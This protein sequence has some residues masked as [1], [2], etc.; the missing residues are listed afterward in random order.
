MNTRKDILFTGVFK[1]KDEETI[2]LVRL[3]NDKCI[4][5]YAFRHLSILSER[6]F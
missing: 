4:I 5:A 3:L 6:I 1:H 2:E